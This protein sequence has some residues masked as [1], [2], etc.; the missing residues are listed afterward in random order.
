MARPQAKKNDGPMDIV[1][2]SRGKL[3]FYLIGAT[4]YVYHAVSLKAKRELLYPKKK[5]KTEADRMESLKHEPFE[6]YRGSM[7]YHRDSNRPTTL[8]VPARQF[9]DAMRSAA[10]RIAGTTKAEVGQLVWVTPENIDMYGVPQ[11]YSAVVNQ[12]GVPDIRTR[13]ILP[14]WACRCNVSYLQPNLNPPA[15][16]KLLGNAGIICGVG[17][18][19]LEKGAL[20]FGQ[21]H[22]VPEN[23]KELMDRYQRIVSEG[24]REAQEQAIKDPLYYDVETEELMSW[25]KDE[26]RRRKAQE[27]VPSGEDEEDEAL[28]EAAD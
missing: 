16:V 12:Q 10:L 8:M 9:K 28:E 3:E 2:V 7:Y 27:V 25:F 23:D 13:A 6:E 19:R 14:E 15:V 17:D 1:E 22:L 4:P 26:V 11:L 20:D 18:A 24:G 21:F 5:K